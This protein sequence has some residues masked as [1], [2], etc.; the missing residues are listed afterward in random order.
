MHTAS[1]SWRCMSSAL[2]LVIVLLAWNKSFPQ[3][4]NQDPQKVPRGFQYSILKPQFSITNLYSFELIEDQ[5]SSWDC[6]LSL[7]QYW[8]NYELHLES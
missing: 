3:K 6:Q 2:S 1:V 7:E 8:V 5:V 4:C